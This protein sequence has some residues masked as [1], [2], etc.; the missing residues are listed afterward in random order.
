MHLKMSS[1]ICFNL[2]QSKVLSSC[3]GLICNERLSLFRVDRG[4]QDQN[5][6]PDLISAGKYSDYKGTGIGISILKTFGDVN[7]IYLKDIFN[8]ESIQMT[9]IP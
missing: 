1:A 8:K 2:D 4:Y 6:F 7:F 5:A 9:S 3:N